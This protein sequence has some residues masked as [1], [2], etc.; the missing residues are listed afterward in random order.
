MQIV[1]KLKAKTDMQASPPVTIAFLGDSVTH[2]CFE[3]F[4]KHDGGFDTVYDTTCA[5]S[6]R[7]REMLAR[8]YPQVQVNI[9]NSGIS[10]DNAPRGAERL[11]RDILPYHPDLVV[12]SYGLNDSMAGLQGLD[13]YRQAVHKIVATLCEQGTEVIF[14]T[15]NYMNTG[16][17]DH[18]PCASLRAFAQKSAE[19]QNSGILKA[20]FAAAVD[21]AGQCGARICDLYAAWERLEAGGVATTELLANYINHPIREYHYYIAVKL[22][23]TMF[24]IE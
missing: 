12:L 20:Y 11:V 4:P 16:L 5:Y 9:I 23:E 22:L 6:T 13:D 17:S 24:D 7:L 3:C 8:L 1:Q 21:E 14:L 10:G 15:Q 2:G 18:L 19:V